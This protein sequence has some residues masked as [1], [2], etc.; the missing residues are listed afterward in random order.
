MK[1]SFLKKESHQRVN[2]KESKLTFYRYNKSM[3]KRIVL[4]I[5]AHVDAGKTT[6]V[7][8]ILFQT[9]V[10]K[11]LGRVLLVK[12]KERYLFCI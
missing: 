7:E 11:K 1:D 4:G 2:K 10:T 3:L 12:S 9:K 6:L 5:L 8:N